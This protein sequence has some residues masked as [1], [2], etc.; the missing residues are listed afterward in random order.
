MNNRQLQTLVEEVSWQYFKKPFNH[1]A[2]FN[3]RLRTTGGRYF[4]TSHHI[5]MNPKQLDVYGRDAFISII[6]HELCHYHL[7]MTGQGYQ[8]KDPAFKALLSEVGGSRYCCLI[9]GTQNNHNNRHYYQCEQCGQRYQ[10][11]RRVNT[12]RL[13]CGKCRGTLKK[14][15]NFGETLTFY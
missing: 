1:Q 10:R 2:I 6:K 5:E 11:L 9:P 3:Q 14:L 7:H 15:R 12:A 13:V 8:H 4:T